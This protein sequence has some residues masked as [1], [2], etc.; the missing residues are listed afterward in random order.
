[1][2]GGFV[3]LRLVED[4]VDTLGVPEALVTGGEVVG[5][6]VRGVGGVLAML[7]V[8]GTEDEVMLGMVVSGLAVVLCTLAGVGG[9]VE[10]VK[11]VDVVKGGVNCASICDRLTTTAPTNTSFQERVIVNYR[12]FTVLISTVGCHVGDNN[13]WCKERCEQPRCLRVTAT[14]DVL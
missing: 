11:G 8:E 13:I 4:E 3:S 2:V 12:F 10:L 7:V 5:G 1:M 9:I 14:K 6:L